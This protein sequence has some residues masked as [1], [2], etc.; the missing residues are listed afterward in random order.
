MKKL[1][2]TLLVLLTFGFTVKGCINR[3]YYGVDRHG[4][5]HAVDQE[6]GF[7]SFNTGFYNTYIQGEMHDLLR[8]LI[9]D[10]SYMV[11]SDY[12]VCLMQVGKTKESLKILQVLNEKYPYEYRICSNLGTAYELSGEN[13][14]ALKYI[15]RGM[16][17][18]PK[19][20]EG[21]EWVHIKVLEAKIKMAKDPFYLKTHRVL[22]LSEK[23]LNDSLIA[24]QIELQLHERFPFCPGPDLIMSQMMIDLADITFNVGSL[25]LAKGY[26]EMG[27]YH[28]GD[29]SQANKDKLAA[30]IALLK[31]YEKKVPTDK[32]G[33]RAKPLDYREYINY[34]GDAENE[35]DWTGITSDPD[36]LLAYVDMTMTAAEADS[37]LK[38]SIGDVFGGEEEKTPEVVAVVPKE[39]Y[40]NT[41]L[42]F[43][44]V[45]LTVL[46]FAF[47]L[48]K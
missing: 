16:I 8:Q 48:R 5:F 32:E 18:Y 22:G 29:S 13:D 35:V 3:Y 9:V 20:H 11:L 42:A 12:A 25:E 1:I 39:N 17:M 38:A 14:S 44:L 23:E 43:V 41:V 28:F 45:L 21:S 40:N 15:K 26:Y 27:I 47:A 6:A 10:R 46:I 19:E 33:E 7:H 34:I 37:L 36:V 4:E 30:C 31:Q 24:Y 2:I